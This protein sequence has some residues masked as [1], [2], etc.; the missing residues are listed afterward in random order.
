MSRRRAVIT[1]IGGEIPATDL[2]RSD[3][4]AASASAV[5]GP[6]H[7]GSRAGAVHP[8]VEHPNLCS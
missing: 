1:G 8:R 4:I 7:E 3:I 6:T 5:Q 2:P